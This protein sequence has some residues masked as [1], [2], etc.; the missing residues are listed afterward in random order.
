MATAQM[1]YSITPTTAE[2]EEQGVAVNEKD[3]LAGNI[4]LQN[5]VKSLCKYFLGL[6][7]WVR[8]QEV[9]EARRQRFYWRNDQYI[10]WKNDAVGFVTATGGQALNADDT[11]VEVPR[12]TDVYN[13]YTP[14][15]E[16][17]LSTLIQNP[18]GVNWQPLDP[19]QAKDI[20]ASKIESNY[21]LM[22]RG[23]SS[24]MVE[25]YSRYAEKMVW[26]KSILTEF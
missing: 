19:S 3:L 9:V 4:E 25:L 2:G 6:D 26:R 12:Y 17:L 1:D 15:G 24:P 21:S 11:T 7:K 8:R 20:T 14:Y 10:Y 16:S 18:P 22:W 23:F 13:I 5:A